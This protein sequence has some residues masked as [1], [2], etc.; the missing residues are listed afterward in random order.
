MKRYLVAA[1]AFGFF[2]WGAQ[3]ADLS[4]TTSPHDVGETVDRFVAAA[5]EAGANVFAT[6]DHAAGARAVDADLAE[7]TLIIFGNPAIGTPII[8]EE[9]RAG[10]DLPLR[11]LVWDQD[12]ETRIAYEEPAALRDRHGIEGADD[13]FEAMEG[14]LA[15]LVSAAT[16]SD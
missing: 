5:E 4:E 13:A 10:L 1:L 2:A 11:V 16:A 8:A 14:A 9:R 12:G 7:T 6:V 15:N 3:A